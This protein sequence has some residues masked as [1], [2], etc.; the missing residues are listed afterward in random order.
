[1][2]FIFEDPEY[3]IVSKNDLPFHREEVWDEEKG[4]IR[5][6]GRDGNKE[7]INYIKYP[8]EH[9]TREYIEKKVLPKY[10]SCPLCHIGKEISPMQASKKEIFK[11]KA[12]KSL[13]Y[14]VPFSIGMIFLVI[15]GTY[16]LKWRSSP[17]ISRE[18]S[19]TK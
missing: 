1:M 18:E 19:E 6:W 10:E 5:V 17:L 14:L 4:I 2:T 15:G 7:K 9:Y 3:F 13:K 8:K 11:E 16:L 12:K